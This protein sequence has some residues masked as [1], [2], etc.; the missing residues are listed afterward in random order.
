MARLDFVSEAIEHA[1]QAPQHGQCDPAILPMA[2]GRNRLLTCVLSTR[3]DVQRLTWCLVVPICV[4][5]QSPYVLL[6][7]TVDGSAAFD[8]RLSAFRPLP[9]SA[10]EAHPFFTHWTQSLLTVLPLQ[11]NCVAPMGRIVRSRGR[12]RP[13]FA[14]VLAAYPNG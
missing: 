2:V 9:G 11:C 10:D 3:R 13:L 8:F 6:L 4:I 14:A 5:V 1:P 7:Q 12:C